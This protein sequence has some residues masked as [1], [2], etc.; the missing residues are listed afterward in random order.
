MTARYHALATGCYSL[1]RYTFRTPGA[2]GTTLT[3]TGVSIPSVVTLVKVTPSSQPY[4][5]PYLDPI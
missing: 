1:D 4:L 2:C 5:D 3:L